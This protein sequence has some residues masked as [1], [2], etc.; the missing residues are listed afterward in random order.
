MTS[1]CSVVMTSWGPSL[2]HNYYDHLEHSVLNINVMTS[3][4]AQGI[5]HKVMT[6][7]SAQVLVHNYYDLLKHAL[8]CT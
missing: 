5:V 1:C 2:V 8:S 3:W 7:W 4:N 6:S